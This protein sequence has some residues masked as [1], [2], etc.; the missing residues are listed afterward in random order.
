MMFVNYYIKTPECWQTTCIT[1]FNLSHF[2][3]RMYYFLNTTENEWQYTSDPYFMRYL[4]AKYT[5]NN[6][7]LICI[8][9]IGHRITKYIQSILINHDLYSPNLHPKRLTKQ[10]LPLWMQIEAGK[11]TN[12]E[13][14]DMVACKTGVWDEWTIQ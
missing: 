10:H 12:D 1:L 9:N 2:F 7:T 4:N 5:T 14:D 11:Y 6:G 8:I 3:T 13:I